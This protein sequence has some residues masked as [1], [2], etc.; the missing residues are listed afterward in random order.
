[1]NDR[2]SIISNTFGLFAASDIKRYDI[3]WR[4]RSICK[5][6]KTRPDLVSI[7]VVLDNVVIFV[8]VRGDS[9]EITVVSAGGAGSCLL[10]T[11]DAAD[12]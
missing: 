6:K 10:Y 12:E 3:C 7:G 11:S 8:G 5:T 9:V 4:Q 1:M 2:I